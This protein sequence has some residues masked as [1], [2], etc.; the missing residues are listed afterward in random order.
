MKTWNIRDEPE[1][2]LRI[3]AEK[4]YKEIDKSYKLLKVMTKLEDA[5]AMTKTIWAMKRQA[6]DIQLE[7][8]RREYSNGTTS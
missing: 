8:I 3:K 6:N 5:I 4:L 2:A 1:E 7:L